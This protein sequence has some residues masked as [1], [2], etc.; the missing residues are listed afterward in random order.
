MKD[1]L[2]KAG[3]PQKQEKAD[4]FGPVSFWDHKGSFASSDGVASF[5]YTLIYR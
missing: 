1:E 2:L 4:R 5:S 3:Y